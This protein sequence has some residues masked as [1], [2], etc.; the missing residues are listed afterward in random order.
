MQSSHKPQAMD[1]TSDEAAGGFA[2]AA[3]ASDTN[4]IHDKLNRKLQTR[5][6]KKDLVAHNIMKRKLNKPPPPR[7][8]AQIPL[9]MA[10]KR[11]KAGMSL[12]WTMAAPPIER[13]D[14]HR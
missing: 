4:T 3:A 11:R 6:D 12:K 8:P 2:A 14:C 7:S 9:K 10:A 5:P 13:A 1:P